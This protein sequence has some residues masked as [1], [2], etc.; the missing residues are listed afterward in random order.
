[1]KKNIFNLS[2]EYLSLS[3]ILSYFFIHNIF[4][5]LLGLTFSFYLININVINNFLIY[6]GKK[7]EIINSHRDIKKDNMDKK[8][9]YIRIELEQEDSN[10]KLVKEI[11]E[12][13]FIPSLNKN[14]DI[15][16]T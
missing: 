10:L 11:E 16:A 9:E 6:I 8:D 7:L 13:G 5:V 3:L 1:M 4:L 2:M 14:N 15:N 12:L